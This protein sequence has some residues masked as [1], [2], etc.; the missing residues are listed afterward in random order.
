[1]TEQGEKHPN[2]KGGRYL[3]DRGYVMVL[4]GKGQY[5]REHRL[6]MESHLRRRLE[7]HEQVHHK[8]GNKQDNRI[9]N[10]ELHTAGS[11]TKH[12]WDKGDFLEVHIQ[13]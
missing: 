9:E 10:L 13:Q 8:N 1:M 2:W 5:V 7:K 12:H 11:H 6:V 4:I 3:T